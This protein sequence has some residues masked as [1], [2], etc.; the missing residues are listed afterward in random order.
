[1]HFQDRN[2]WMKINNEFELGSLGS[3]SEIVFDDVWFEK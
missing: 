2:S 3:F 1:M